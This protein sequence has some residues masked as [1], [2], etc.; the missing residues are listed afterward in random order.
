MS[1][2]PLRARALRR[3]AAA[4]RRYPRPDDGGLDPAGLVV[5]RATG[6]ADVVEFSGT[7]LPSSP[8]R[9]RRKACSGRSS[10]RPRD[11]SPA[12]PLMSTGSSAISRILVLERGAVDGEAGLRRLDSCASGG[13][14]F[15]ATPPGSAPAF[16][17][18][19]PVVLRSASSASFSANVRRRP[20]RT[21]LHV[22]RLRPV[23]SG[24]LRPARHDPASPARCSAPSRTLYLG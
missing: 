21:S 20:T 10:S 15:L 8:R 6:E 12:L 3:R 17:E 16:V 7:G 14:R 11:R 19:A 13:I 4:F 24:L 9:T 2:D 18:R 23:R 22:L 1:F 5:V